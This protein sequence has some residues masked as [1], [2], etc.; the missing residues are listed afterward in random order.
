[1][2]DPIAPF[3]R[4]LDHCNNA[5]LPGGRFPFLLGTAQIG[6]VAPQ[7]APELERRGVRHENNQLVLDDPLRLEPLGEELGQAKLFRF[8]SEAFDV[9]A[10]PDGPVLAQ[11][12]RG[13]LPSFG[14]RADGVH[15]NGLVEK[16]DGT[17]LWVGRRAADKLLDPNKL[18]HLVAGG[19]P[20]GYDPLRTLAK[21]GAEECSLPPELAHA[22][23]P[24]GTISYAMARPE[25]LRRDRLHC[26]DVVLPD[27]FQPVPNDG[28]VAEFMLIPLP[29]AFRLVRDTDEFKFNVNL[30]LI[31][32]FLRRGLIDPRSDGGVLLRNRLNGEASQ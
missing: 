6:W 4:H 32:L 12:D 31:D 25:G 28:E 29:E 21:E 10:D 24:V 27:D 26:F 8:R 18:D 3:L 13:A 11:L 1:M 19:V 30:V 15:L 20:A 22:A 2:T 16:P 7:M 5:R 14:I 9:R 23:V 17:H